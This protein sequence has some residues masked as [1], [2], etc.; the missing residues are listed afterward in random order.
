MELHFAEV[1]FPHEKG[2]W[3]EFGTFAKWCLTCSLAIKRRRGKMR[4]EK[5]KIFLQV[6]CNKVCT[7]NG[8]K[9]RGQVPRHKILQTGM[10]MSFKRGLALSCPVSL[11]LREKDKRWDLGSPTHPP[12]LKKHCCRNCNDILWASHK[13][14]SETRIEVGKPD[15]YHFTMTFQ[16]Q[17]QIQISSSNHQET[18]C[19]S[20]TN[21]LRKQNMQNRQ[22][23]RII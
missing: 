10:K 12:T 16:L 18:C 5:R 3:S 4:E 9:K 15:F 19:Q 13:K 14:A 23:M 11:R 7:V 2:S 22:I 20:C 21:G 1:Y 17:I 8:M 6:N